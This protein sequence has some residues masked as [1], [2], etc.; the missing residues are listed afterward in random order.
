MPGHQRREGCL[1]CVPLLLGLVWI[2]RTRV[3][4]LAGRVDDGNLDSGPEA[5]VEAEG[6]AVA[7]RGGQQQVGEVP[8]EHGDRVGL[9]ALPQPH[10]SVDRRSD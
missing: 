7:C 1:G 9:G 2:D 10:P 5:R 6:G 4:D 8:G 3:Q